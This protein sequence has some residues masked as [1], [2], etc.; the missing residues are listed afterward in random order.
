[1]QCLNP[2]HY[3]PQNLGILKNKLYKI[4]VNPFS[5]NPSRW[6]NT[7]KNVW[8]CLTIL[9]GWRLNTALNPPLAAPVQSYFYKKKKFFT[10]ITFS[11]ENRLTEPATIGVLW[12][13][14]FLNFFLQ[15]SQENACARICLLIKLQASSQRL[16]YEK[17]SGTGIFL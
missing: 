14:V 2:L 6:S 1:M 16:Y 5:A 8:M 9:R 10:W 13:K 17:D 15:N 11:Q 4:H 12:L 7:L 3:S